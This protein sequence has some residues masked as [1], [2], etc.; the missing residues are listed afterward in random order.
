MFSFYNVIGRSLRPACLIAFVAMFSASSAVGQIAFPDFAHAR[1]VVFV[2]DSGSEVQ[3]VGTHSYGLYR[4]VPGAVGKNRWSDPAG[5]TDPITVNDMVEV[6][7][8]RLLLGASGSGGQQT[9]TDATGLFFSDDK[10]VTWTPYAKATFDSL[11]VHTV[12]A[13]TQSAADST[14][15]LSADDGN[16]FIST[17]GG[18]SWIFN[19]RLPGGSS[20][21]PWALRAHPSIAGTVYAGTP[22]YGVFVSNDHGGFWREFTDNSTLVVPGNGWTPNSGGNYVF[23]LEMNPA[24]PNQMFAATAKG[25]W[26]FDDVTNTGGTWARVA[27]SDS[28]FV[29]E[30][31]V[32]TV[33][34]HPE[35]RSIAF[36]A[37]G[38]TMYQATWGFGV[39]TMGSAAFGG[40]PNAGDITGLALRGAEVS[41][42]AVAPSGAV[43][44]GTN[45]GVY[46]IAAASATSVTPQGETPGSYVLSQ[47]YPNPFNPNTSIAFELPAQA[48]V[49]LAVFDVLGRQVAELANGAFPAGAHSVSFDASGLPSGL[50]I[51][52]LDA[53]DKSMAR[54]MT[55][56]K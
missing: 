35:V 25:V 38:T 41:V 15:F 13:I 42:V 21:T 54:T 32:T 27:A 6:A 51:Y 31:G 4:S 37:A 34:L 39:L 16:I 12:Q 44:A 8:G 19:G 5:L 23:D 20:Q 53:G 47:N 49:S 1:S 30:D 55:L 7:G 29:L 40:T 14:I 33:K 28:S 43:Y 3:L 9:D 10:G 45:G 46:E 26:R 48:N 11:A 22:G 17:N 2:D 24:S 50:Y 56:V 52:R 36:N 18:T